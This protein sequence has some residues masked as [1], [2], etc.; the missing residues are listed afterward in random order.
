MY[1][2]VKPRPPQKYHL[3]ISLR[4]QRCLGIYSIIPRM[5]RGFPPFIDAI[6]LWYNDEPWLQSAKSAFSLSVYAQS[7]ELI[8]LVFL[9]LNDL[10]LNEAWSKLADLV[11]HCLKVINPL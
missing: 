4:L 8:Q 7:N 6:V 2:T 5:C 11:Q 1:G 10:C 9:H 3:R